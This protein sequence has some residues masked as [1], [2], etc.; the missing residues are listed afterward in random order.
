MTK[1]K[2]MV[3]IGTLVL[4]AMTPGHALAASNSNLLVRTTA[5]LV[6]TDSSSDPKKLNLSTGDDAAFAVDGTYFFRP[7]F[8]LNALATFITPNVRSGGS[9]LG[10]IS[11]VP[12]TF[13]AQYHFLPDAIVRPYIGLGFNYNFNGKTTG[14]L[15]TLKVNV[16]N[17]VG[18][19]AQLGAD[20]ML[21]K[22]LSLNADLKYLRFDTDVNVNGSKADRL[23]FDAIIVGVGLGFWL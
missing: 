1:T 9:S 8:A 15:S 13:T 16:K 6:L 19:V 14:T 7:N 4:A 10:S 3:G 17:T 12:P 20:Y 21:T 11:V 5:I 18:F 22:T 2:M 23:K